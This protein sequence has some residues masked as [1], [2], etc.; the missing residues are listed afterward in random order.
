MAVETGGNVEG[1]VLGEVAEMNGVK[2][3]GLD[4]LPCFAPETASQMYSSNLYNLI[5][6]YWN[7]ETKQFELKREDEII[8]NCLLT[9]E[10]K[11]VNEKL[12]GK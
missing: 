3:I 7:K 5:A 9:F 4:P 11:I 10:G 12:M 8:K 1:S 6:Q 2:I